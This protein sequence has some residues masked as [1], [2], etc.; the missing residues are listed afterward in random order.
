VA[1]NQKTKNRHKLEKRHS[2]TMAALDGSRKV[3]SGSGALRPPLL[4]LPK[5]AELHDRTVRPLLC[6]LWIAC[7]QLQVS[8]ETRWQAAILLHRYCIACSAPD[9]QSRKD[10]AVVITVVCILLACKSQEEPRRLRDIIN[11]AHMLQQPKTAPLAVDAATAAADVTTAAAD[12]TAADDISPAAAEVSSCKRQRLNDGTVDKLTGTPNTNTLNGHKD[13]A[14]P[15]DTENKDWRCRRAGTVSAISIHW[16]SQ[17]PSLDET[18]WQ[19]K[20]RLVHAEQ[21][22]LRWLAFDVAV[23]RVHAAT[24]FLVKKITDR[25]AAETRAVMTVGAWKRL[26]NAVFFVP[27]LHHGILALAVAAV[28]LSGQDWNRQAAVGDAA[29]IIDEEWLL[30]TLAS[31]ARVSQADVQAAAQSL[32]T[33]TVSLEKVAHL[34]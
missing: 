7:A 4:N 9:Q 30:T 27:A 23:G 20:E 19:S 29:T 16:N 6:S 8:V 31:S 3:P 2:I 13:S 12:V 33:A 17:P 32:R 24:V 26:N 11:C 34:E 18:Y 28:L 1:E 14:T 10:D 22:V 21:T 25:V 15:V 5:D